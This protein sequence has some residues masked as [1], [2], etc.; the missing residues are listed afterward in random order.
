MYLRYSQI[1]SEFIKSQSSLVFFGDK[2]VNE[3]THIP[4]LLVSFQIT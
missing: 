1:E 2:I 3:H 4:N